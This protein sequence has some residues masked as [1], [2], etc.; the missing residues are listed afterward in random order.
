[1]KILLAECVC[2]YDGALPRFVY[3]W[4]AG[5]LLRADRADA[6]AHQEDGTYGCLDGWAGRRGAAE[7]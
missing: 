4:A 6:G 5:I 7:G 1:M 2:P 3:G